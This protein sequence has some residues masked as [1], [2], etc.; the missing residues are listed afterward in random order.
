MAQFV[1]GK[2]LLF[3]PDISGFT[4][5]VHNTEVSHSQHI[6]SELL[7]LLID[8]NEMGLELVEIE[9]DALFY[10]KQGK[11]PTYD[12]LIEQVKK[13]FIRFHHHLKLYENRRICQ[14]GAC[15]SAHHQLKLKF[16]IH[17]GDINFI[18]IKDRVKPHG[19]PVIAV[20]RLLKNSIPHN[21]YILISQELGKT[22]TSE[23]GELNIPTIESSETYDEIGQIDYRYFAPDAWSAEIPN[24]PA[25]VIDKGKKLTPVEKSIDIEKDILDVYEMLTNLKYRRGWSPELKDLKFNE[26]EI[27]KEGTEHTCVID[28]QNIQFISKRDQSDKN[29]WI[30]IEQTTDIPFTNK[31]SNYF[32]LTPKNGKTRVDISIYIEPKNFTSRIVIPFMK[33]KLS[34]S[35]VGILNNF[36]AYAE[37]NTV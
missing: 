3:I 1:P 24:V 31:V 4:A 35:I 2:A 34:K 25:I 18:K 36:K 21:E 9:G 6:I 27:N 23:S 20:H 5:F 22:I 29:E 28:G 26:T 14:C 11:L 7:E 19:S 10:F 33:M 17:Y 16:V 30:Y 12:E 13:M 15:T 37:S 32:I 8:S